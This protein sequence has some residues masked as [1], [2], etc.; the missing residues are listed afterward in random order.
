MIFLVLAIYAFFYFISCT[1][2]VS[3]VNAEGRAAYDEQAAN[4][5]RRNKE[6]AEKYDYYY[7]PQKLVTQDIN[8][9]FYSD[10]SLR[11][12]GWTGQ[13][14]KKGTYYADSHGRT[15][16]GYIDQNAKHPG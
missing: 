16:A 9:N 14:Y 8:D 2:A 1:A 6:F 12:D 10:G 7:S 4:A 13:C 5:H 15:A 11:K 3:Q